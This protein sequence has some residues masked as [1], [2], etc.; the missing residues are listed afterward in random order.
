MIFR[1]WLN[2]TH[3]EALV[4]LAPLAAVPGAWTSAQELHEVLHRNDEPGCTCFLLAMAFDA[5][6]GMTDQWKHDCADC[7]TDSTDERYMVRD[8]VWK[9]AGMCYFGFL[10]VGCIEHRLGRR[11]ADVGLNH[12]PRYHRSS[13]LVDRLASAPPCAPAS[14]EGNRS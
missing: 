10:C 3:R 4:E 9:A 6:L 8:D 2:E 13:R 5:W 12:D 11:F 14:P 1:S 7:G